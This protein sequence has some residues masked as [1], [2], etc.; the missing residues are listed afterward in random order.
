MGG[1]DP[2]AAGNYSRSSGERSCLRWIFATRRGQLE[3]E[4]RELTYDGGLLELLKGTNHHPAVRKEPQ[5]G[6]QLVLVC[7]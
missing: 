5:N 1:G 6:A 4:L 3:P 7:L 2:S